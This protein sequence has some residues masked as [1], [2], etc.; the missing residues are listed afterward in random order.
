MS[1]V[2]FLAV[3]L[4]M[5]FSRSAGAQP[6]SGDSYANLYSWQLGTS[7]QP[8]SP[9]AYIWDRY[10]YN[11]PNVSPYLNLM[12]VQPN[13]GTDYFTYVQPLEEKQEAENALAAKSPPTGGRAPI[14]S[15]SFSGGM[16]HSSA[17]YN[18]YYGGRGGAGE[19]QIVPYSTNAPSRSASYYYNH[20]YGGWQGRN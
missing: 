9:Q 10:Y 12:R 8:L 2:V 11:N 15:K 4:V 1:R 3:A 17:T 7:G 18:P 20:Y 19:S 16:Y 13:G 5:A 6:F 14:Q